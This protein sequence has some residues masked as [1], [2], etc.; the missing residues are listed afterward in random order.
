MSLLLT[1][2]AA[3]EAGAFF[4]PDAGARAL[5]RGAAYVA[6]VEDL[7]A[8]YWNPA[9]LVRLKRPVLE[10]ELGGL[11]PTV[12]FAR[13]SEGSAVFDPIRNR[14]VPVPIP[15]IAYSPALPWQDVH[16]AAGIYTPLGAWYRYPPDGAQ[17]YALVSST[18]TQAN[19]GVTVAWQQGPVAIGAGCAFSTLR[20]DY[21]IAA[22]TALEA[23]DDPAYDVVT[24]MSAAD[25]GSLAG[26]AGL[27][28]APVPAVTIGLSAQA[29]VRYAARGELRVDFS[30][31]A[32]Y[33]GASELGQIVA[34][35]EAVDDD[36]VLP[37]VLPWIVRAGLSVHM[38]R[39]EVELDGVWEAWGSVPSP[40]VRD[41]DLSIATTGGDPIVVE[42]DLALPVHFG[43]AWSLRLGAE[44]DREASALRAGLFFEHPAVPASSHSVAFTDG[45]KIGYGV[46]A[47]LGS[48]RPLEWTVGFSQS[49]NLVRTLDRSAVFQL[50]ID[51]VTGDVGYGETVGNGVLRATHTTL[52]SQLRWSR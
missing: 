26:N 8:Q 33:T 42:D 49:T 39:T 48:D 52:L 30:D 11:V 21:R 19:A 23:G 27:L 7:T 43:N 44:R 2:A 18:L 34:Q 38:G 12:R 9:G 37:V 51:P 10:L 32:F 13:A 4:V 6:G 17:R 47:S 22:T 46:G 16:V 24:S 1:L 35:P 36:V 50:H 41:L 31:N 14:A 29:P 45:T 3:A 20:T 40:T 28:V 5:G 15:R 25:R